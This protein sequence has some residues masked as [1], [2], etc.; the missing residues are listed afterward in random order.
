V[1]RQPAMRRILA[2]GLVSYGPSMTVLGLWGGP[3]FADVFGLDAA[4]IGQALFALALATTAGL[5]AAGPLGRLLGGHRRVVLGMAGIEAGCFAALAAL[6][7][8]GLWLCG[9]LLFLALVC[10]TFY[11][12]LAAHCRSLFPDHLVGR[13]N[14]I[15]NLSG[16]VGVALMQLLS[17]PIVRLFPRDGGL[18]EPLAYRLV[19]ALLAASILLGMAI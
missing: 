18:A 6:A 15:L 5:L 3:Y 11:L 16:I 9:G 2:M 12:P 14:T 1:L 17:G 4:R 10:Q 19:F 13:A 8:S 7:E